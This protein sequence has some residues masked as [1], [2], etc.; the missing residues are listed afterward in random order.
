ME[1]LH[2]KQVETLLGK[3]G[4]THIHNQ[5]I[6]IHI[7]SYGNENL[8]YITSNYLQNLLNIPFGAIPKLIKDIH[9]NPNHPENHNIKITNKKLPYMCVYKDNKWIYQ[10]KKEAI[11][12]IVDKGYNLLEDHYHQTKPELEDKTMDKFQKFQQ[13]YSID[14]KEVKKTL[15]KDAELTILNES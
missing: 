7:N 2:A 11:D 9:F 10:D 5:N 4:N 12:E 1:L 3:V 8:E 6:S 13:K 14:D 15:I